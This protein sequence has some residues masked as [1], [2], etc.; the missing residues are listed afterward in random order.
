MLVVL[1]TGFWS[2][3]EAPI[4]LT[5]VGRGCQCSS[6]RPH[7]SI[8]TLSCYLQSSHFIM[9]VAVQ[10]AAKYESRGLTANNRMIWRANLVTTLQIS[11]AIKDHTRTNWVDVKLS[12]SFP[13]I[14]WTICISTTW[15]TDI[16]RTMV[17]HPIGPE[18]AWASSKPQK[19][20][21]NCSRTHQK[22]FAAVFP[23]TLVRFSSSTC[24]ALWL[25]SHQSRLSHL[26]ANVCLRSV[27]QK[28]HLS[29][30]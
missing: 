5:N 3:H 4:E 27:W 30:L 12:F 13:E 11:D 21:T 29:N 24:P 6:N 15:S 7:R 28:Q 25:V 22:T 2:S 10:L 1:I 8:E 14:L 20:A 18:H 19:T 9:I 26:I 23:F 17:H 16:V